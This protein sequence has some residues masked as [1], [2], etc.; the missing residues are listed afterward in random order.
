MKTVT[1][2][3][4]SL[5]FVLSLLNHAN[6]EVVPEKISILEMKNALNA[7][8]SELIRKEKEVI[9]IHR[10]RPIGGRIYVSL[11]KI[12]IAKGDGSTFY[13]KECLVMS[14]I[15]SGAWIIN[16][17]RCDEVEDITIRE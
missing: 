6:A 13:D 8:N 4:L 3:V 7:L 14:V 9:E 10:A 15:N 17:K 5:S 2:F 12:I 1:L 11:Y 16:D